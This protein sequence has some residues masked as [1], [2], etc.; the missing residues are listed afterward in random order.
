MEESIPVLSM[1]PDV[2]CSEPEFLQLKIKIAASKIVTGSNC[3]IAGWVLV[4]IRKSG[5]EFL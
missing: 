1:N 5:Q 3:R 2:F 4:N